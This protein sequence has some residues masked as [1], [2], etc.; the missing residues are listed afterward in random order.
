MAAQSWILHTQVSEEVVVAARYPVVVCDRS[1]LDNYE[2]LL[3]ASGRR[4]ALEGLVDHWTTTYDLLV[5]VP[6]V[7]P[8]RPDGIRAAIGLTQH[9]RVRLK[10]G[11]IPV[12]KAELGRLREVEME[13]RHRE[14]REQIRKASEKVRGDAPIVEKAPETPSDD[15]SETA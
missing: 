7:D 10:D 4:P 6:I 11:L 8:P 13:G 9:G 12:T 3:L 1:V 5:H 2:Y 14:A 15:S